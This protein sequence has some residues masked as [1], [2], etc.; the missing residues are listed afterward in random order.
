MRVSTRR[1]APHRL[2]LGGE[3]GEARSDQVGIHEFPALHEVGQELGGEGGLP[4]PVG[5]GDQVG[6]R[7]SVGRHVSPRPSRP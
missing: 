6:G 1:P 2:A 7:G 4:G 5:T 3:R